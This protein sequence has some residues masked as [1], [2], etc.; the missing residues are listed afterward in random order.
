MEGCRDRA[1]NQTSELK[2]ITSWGTIRRFPPP[3]HHRRTAMPSNSDLIVQ[4]LHAECHALLPFVSGPE[5]H[6]QTAYTV[7]L[8]LFRRLLA[9]G[10]ALVKLFFLTRAAQ[11]PSDPIAANGTRL[12]YH[13]QRPTGHPRLLRAAA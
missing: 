13:D 11:R 2:D 6:A 8:T 7:E 4:Q 3:L 12:P 5:A 9:L 10:A 1:V